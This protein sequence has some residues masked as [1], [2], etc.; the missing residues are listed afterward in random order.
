MASVEYR[1]MNLVIPENDSEWREHFKLARTNHQ[2]MLRACKQRR[3]MRSPP[4]H[5]PPADPPRLQAVPA[6]ALPP[7][8]RLPVVPV[9]RVGVEAGERQGPHSLLRGRAPRDP[10][11][12]P[13]LG[14]PS[15]G[16]RG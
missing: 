15:G 12:L 6:H 7:E 13:G 3:L 10:A 2:L 4:S 9:A 8:P 5:H 1:G 11:R 16:G 14:P